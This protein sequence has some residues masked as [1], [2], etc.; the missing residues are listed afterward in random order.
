MVLAAGYDAWNR[1]VS[2]INNDTDNDS[3]A[4]EYDGLHRSIVRRENTNDLASSS[5][6]AVTHF[7]YNE[8]WQ[9][10][11]ERDGSGILDHLT[12]GFFSYYHKLKIA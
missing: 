9:C 12:L 11:E 5:L 4:Y 1:L 6:D 10:V 7:Y 2:L 8:K 3:A